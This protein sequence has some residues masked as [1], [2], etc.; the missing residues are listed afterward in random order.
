MFF[1]DVFNS[2]DEIQVIQDVQMERECL[3]GK[4]REESI[5]SR[6]ILKFV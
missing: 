5:S 6:Q 3:K 2:E 1:H 4:E